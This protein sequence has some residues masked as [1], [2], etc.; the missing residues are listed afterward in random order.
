MCSSDLW[1]LAAAKGQRLA[2]SLVLTGVDMSAFSRAM[3]WPAFPG[4]LGGAILLLRWVDDRFELEGGLSASLFD[5][6][7]DI[8]RLSLRQPFGPHPV[9]RGDIALRQLDLAAITSVFDFGDIS[10]RLDGSIDGLRLVDWNPV[11]FK[12]SL[13]ADGG[14]Q[15]SQQ[16]VNNL[17]SVGGGGVA[18]GLQGAVLKLFKTFGYNRIGLNCTLQGTVCQMNGLGREIGRASCRER[19]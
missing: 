8:T 13:L 17:T 1:R 18:A 3:G 11:A 14:G 9:L 19:V 15:I 6:F 5:G 2:T 12:A 4:T 16:A 7:V 10:G